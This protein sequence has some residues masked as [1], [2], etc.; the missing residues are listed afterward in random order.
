MTLGLNILIFRVKEADPEMIGKLPSLNTVNM[1]SSITLLLAILLLS[2]SVHLN[3]QQVEKTLVKAFNLA[4]NNVV[5]L[6][7]ND[8][9]QVIVNE[10]NQIQMR[11]I[12]TVSLE[13]G[14]DLML[15]SLV[16]VGRY[17]L[18]SVVEPGQLRIF[19]PGLE[20]EVKLRNGGQLVENINFEI[21]TP[22]NIL[23]KTKN[24]DVVAEKSTS[25]L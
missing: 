1:K 21:F 16:K 13:N 14:S 18:D 17:N 7:V 25:D 4:G 9:S 24:S 20:R 3:G 12:M 10:W 2:T 6:D 5:L 22:S 8:N 23:V 15:K 11:V 19:L